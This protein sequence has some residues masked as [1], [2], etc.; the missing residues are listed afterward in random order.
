[1]ADLCL[2]CG[3]E[4]LWASV[5]LETGVEDICTRLQPEDGEPLPTTNSSSVCSL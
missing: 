2:V 3:E 4:D 1:M 5:N